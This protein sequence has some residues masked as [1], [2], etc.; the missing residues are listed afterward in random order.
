MSLVCLDNRDANSVTGGVC[1]AHPQHEDS[2]GKPTQGKSS[3]GGICNHA[4][5]RPAWWTHSAA[6]RGLCVRGYVP[7][8]DSDELER[9]ARRWSR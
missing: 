1:L 9:I 8:L 6:P 5:T 2:H 7:E 3:S 4:N